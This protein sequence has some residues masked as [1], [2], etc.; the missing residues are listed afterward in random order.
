MHRK[1]QL[2]LCTWIIK[3]VEK[4][5]SRSPAVPHTPFFL[6]L[7]GEIQHRREKRTA[8]VLFIFPRTKWVW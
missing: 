1:W 7:S 8:V 2:A 5:N 6:F 3:E 4:K